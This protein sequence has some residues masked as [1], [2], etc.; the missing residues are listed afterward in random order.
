MDDK[1]YAEF[2][3]R[4]DVA[5]AKDAAMT[6]EEVAA[7]EKLQDETLSEAPP[8]PDEN[9]DGV[10]AIFLKKTPRTRTAKVRDGK[11]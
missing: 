3:K 8:I 7:W 9:G 1:E 2:V 10:V 11:K 5:R 4:M 6:P